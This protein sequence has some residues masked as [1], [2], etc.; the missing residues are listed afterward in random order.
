MLNISSHNKMP[1]TSTALG[2]SGAGQN[3]PSFIKKL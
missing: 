2:R 1:N 3:I